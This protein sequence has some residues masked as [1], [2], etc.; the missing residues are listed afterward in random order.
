MK[1]IEFSRWLFEL[2]AKQHSQ[3]S[4]SGS[5]FLPCLGLPSKSHRGN[6]ISSI[7]LESPHQVDMKN[8][9]KSSK[10]F[11]G[12]FNTLETHIANILPRYYFN[13]LSMHSVGQNWL[14]KT[15]LCGQTISGNYHDNWEKSRSN[16]L[17]CAIH[18]WMHMVVKFLGVKLNACQQARGIG[19]SHIEREFSKSHQNFMKK[20]AS[21]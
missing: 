20:L 5:I 14:G 16:S 3:F 19:N 8:V 1:E 13:Y 17:H 9:F 21:F 15:I 11:F 7:F 12:Y 6:S 18:I 4:P 2:P 10:H